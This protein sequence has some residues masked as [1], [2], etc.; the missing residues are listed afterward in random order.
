MASR[1]VS[2]RRGGDRGDIAVAQ[3]GKGDET[4]EHEVENLDYVV[5]VVGL[6]NVEGARSMGLEEGVQ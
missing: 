4:V 2:A 1:T 3:G 5:E 6:V